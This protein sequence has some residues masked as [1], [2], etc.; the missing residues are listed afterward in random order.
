MIKED[1]H[2]TRPT[3]PHLGIYKWQISNSLSIIH[4][5]TGVGL[6]FSFMLIC[7]WGI[8]VVVSQKNSSIIALS[9]TVLFKAMIYMSIYALF[10]HACLG[11]RHLI[12]DAG[13]GYSIKI[14]NFS[15]ISAIAV[16][17]SITMYIYYKMSLT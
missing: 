5:I 4:R 2:K 11:I 3:S 6:Y 7:W 10:F 14:M 13:Y 8:I 15:G 1:L 17:L 16:S 12:W 9:Q